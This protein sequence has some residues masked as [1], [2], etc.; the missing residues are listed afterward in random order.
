MDLRLCID[1]SA[2]GITVTITAPAET[3]EVRALT[4]LLSPLSPIPGWQGERMTPLDPADILCFYASD[5][6]VFA[7]TAQGEYLIRLRLYELED[8]LDS[9]RFV[10]ISHSEIVNLRQVTD[11]DLSLAGS[12]KMTLHGGHVCWASRRYVKK[13]KQ[14]VGLGKKEST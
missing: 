2:K 11:L 4:A 10:R 3:E 14:A 7:R 6:A 9:H 13:I 5:K 1:P 12:I 8:R